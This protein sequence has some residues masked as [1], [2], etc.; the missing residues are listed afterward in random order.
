MVNRTVKFALNVWA[1]W[2]PIILQ[3]EGGA[4][5]K[6]WTTPG[7]AA[8]QGGTG[9]DRQSGVDARCLCRRQGAHRLGHARHG[10]ALHG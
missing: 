3:N 7:G 8:V 9:P 6:D 5:G 4:A 2:A 10:A 1:G